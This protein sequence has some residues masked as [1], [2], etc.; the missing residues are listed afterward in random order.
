MFGSSAFFHKEERANVINNGIEGSLTNK[1]TTISI[2]NQFIVALTL[3]ISTSHSGQDIANPLSITSNRA[4]SGLSWNDDRR[5]RNKQ[6]KS[7]MPSP[8]QFRHRH[9]C[10]KDVLARLGLLRL[11][12][13]FGT[14]DGAQVLCCRRSVRISSRMLKLSH[15]WRKTCST[16]VPNLQV[17]SRWWC[18]LVGEVGSV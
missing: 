18:Q 17:Q 14:P 10:H 6:G 16:L 15:R 7:Q 13:S 8:T 4:S 11:R 1:E 5:R 3:L 9:I 2:S 12:T